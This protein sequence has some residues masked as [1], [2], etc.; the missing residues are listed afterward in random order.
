ME[1]IRHFDLLKAF[2]Y[3]DIVLKSDF[4]SLGKDLF[5]SYACATCPEL[6]S[7]ISTMIYPL[8]SIFSKNKD[9][10]TS[11]TKQLAERKSERKMAVTEPDD[12]VQQTL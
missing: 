6:P 3:I 9:K 1:K 2:G 11:R 10:L 4:F 7:Y 5:Y 12:P 8:H